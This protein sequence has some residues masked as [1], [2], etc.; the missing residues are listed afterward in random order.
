MNAQTDKQQSAE[1]PDY[2][3]NWN[4]NDIY[5]NWD[6]WSKDFEIIKQEI[7]KKLFKYLRASNGTILPK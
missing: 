7:T 6:A 4:F 2:R 1:T 3:Y 5:P